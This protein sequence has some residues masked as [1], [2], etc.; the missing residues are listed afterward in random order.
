MP[1]KPKPQQPNTLHLN[2]PALAGAFNL[3]NTSALQTLQTSPT[4]AAKPILDAWTAERTQYKTAISLRGIRD[5]KLLALSQDPKYTVILTS[6]MHPA[7]N[8]AKNGGRAGDG[9]KAGGN[10]DGTNLVYLAGLWYIGRLVRAC[11]E[12]FPRSSI[13]G[14]EGGGDKGDEDGDGDAKAKVQLDPYDVLHG[15]K[16]LKWVLMS[17]ASGKK[18]RDRKATGPVWHV[19]PATATSTAT[20]A[21]V[22]VE[23]GEGG[24]DG[25]SDAVATKQGADA[26][27]TS[28]IVTNKDDPAET[29]AEDIKDEPEAEAE[30][31]ESVP[32]TEADKIDSVIKRALTDDEDYDALSDAE[33][34]EAK[35]AKP[36]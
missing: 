36:C 31:E 5:T 10:V 34:H 28:D 16:L 8:A 21:A 18:I 12:L 26:E 30:P 1:S 25:E 17:C 2:A 24:E 35:K 19:Q 6:E 33:K 15:W 13:A 7:F 9:G 11:P 3:P 22:K 14:N 27:D 23:G 20:A 4:S 32:K 29:G